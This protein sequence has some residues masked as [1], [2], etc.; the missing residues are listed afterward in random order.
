MSGEELQTDENTEPKSWLT[1]VIECN[2]S[3]GRG[4]ARSQLN[5]V[6][7]LFFHFYLLVLNHPNYFSVRQLS[8]VESYYFFVWS[9]RSLA[10]SLK[11]GYCM[12]LWFS[13]KRKAVE[14]LLAYFWGLIKINLIWSV[15]SIQAFGIKAKAWILKFFDCLYYYFIFT[16]LI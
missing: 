1:N 10:L 5:A 16:R 4:N 8:F 14:T 12:N 2:N 6:I 11:F 13:I 9:Q 7:P 15:Y 3:L